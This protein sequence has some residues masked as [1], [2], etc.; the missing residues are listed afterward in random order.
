MDMLTTAGAAARPF[1]R[2]LLAESRAADSGS[3][4]HTHHLPALDL[5]IREA[6]LA[7]EIMLAG[8]GLHTG[9][10]VVARVAPAAPG[11]GIVFRLRR[12]RG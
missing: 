1:A 10:R 4:C 2:D 9:G 8:P 3:A 5:P 11:H 7:G 6:T 12:A